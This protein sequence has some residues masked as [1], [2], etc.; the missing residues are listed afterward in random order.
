MEDIMALTVFEWNDAAVTQLR[1]MLAAGKCYAEIAKAMGVSKYAVNGKIGR[2]GLRSR[3]RH[4]TGT[5]VGQ[6]ALRR[7]R[8][9]RNQKRDEQHEQ[10]YIMVVSAPP[11]DLTRA[12][13][14]PCSFVLEMKPIARYCDVPS[15]PGKSYCPAHHEL[16]VLAPAA[17]LHRSAA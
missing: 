14:A 15:L 2:L 1:T 4:T 9:S 7:A 8:K 17:D 16:C 10:H 13:I 6:R 3:K 5:Y 12:K 11:P